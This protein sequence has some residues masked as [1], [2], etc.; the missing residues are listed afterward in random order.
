MGVSDSVSYPPRA[1]IDAWLI[2]ALLGDAASVKDDVE[3]P[4]NLFP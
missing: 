3:W 2:A 1:Q 4:Y